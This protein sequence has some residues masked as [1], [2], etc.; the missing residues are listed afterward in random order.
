MLIEQT[1]DIILRI[2]IKNFV[3]EWGSL[4]GVVCFD[5]CVHRVH[6]ENY[7]S[8]CG[9]IDDKFNKCKPKCKVFCRQRIYAN[10]AIWRWISIIFLF[11]SS[12]KDFNTEIGSIGGNKKKKKM[13]NKQTHYQILFN[14]YILCLIFLM[15]SLILISYFKWTKYL[16]MSSNWMNV[17]NNFCC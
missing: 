5:V 3:I 10:V 17:G 2:L 8:F 16:K 15:K 9:L 1:I 11:I 6:W 12:L 4:W 14:R 13:L 7:F